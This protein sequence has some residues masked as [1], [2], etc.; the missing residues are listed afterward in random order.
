MDIVNKLT[1]ELKIYIYNFIDVDTRIALIKSTYGSLQPFLEKIRQNNKQKN[2]V[3]IFYKYLPKEESKLTLYK[4][5]KLGYFNGSIIAFRMVEDELINKI[6]LRIKQL[7][8]LIA[9]K[10]QIFK[11]YLTF[12]WYTRMIEKN[13]M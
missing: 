12:I 5:E 10:S 11:M 7:E 13:I 4:M 3:R 9:Y 6:L 8:K 1:D 2:M